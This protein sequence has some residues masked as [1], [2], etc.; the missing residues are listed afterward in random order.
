M[1][2]NLSTSSLARAITAVPRVRPGPIGLDLGQQR[3]H[4]VQMNAGPEGPVIRARRSVAY[5][6]G[7]DAVLASPKALKALYREATRRMGFSGHRVVTC[8]PAELVQLW[9]ESYRMTV[10]R[11]EGAA[12]LALALERVGGTAEDWVV[13]YIPLR[14]ASADAVDRE[15]IIACCRREHVMQRL[16][17][18]SRA[19]LDVEAVEVGP[20]AVRRL[21]AAVSACTAQENLLTVNVGRASTF[22]TIFAGRRLMVE[23]EAAVGEADL[24]DRVARNLEIDLAQAQRLVYQHGFVAPGT[25][26]AEFSHTLATILKPRLLD[27]ADE[28]EKVVIYTASKLRGAAVDRIFLLGSLARWPGAADMLNRLVAL[29]VE[30][31]NPVATFMPRGDAPVDPASTTGIFAALAAGSALRGIVLDE[32]DDPSTAVGAALAAGSAL[33][34][35]VPG[36]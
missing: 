11:S 21:V 1:L 31:M 23:R 29:P 3:L 25:A 2:E 4:L 5:P 26:G 13:D 28:I 30:V 36:V 33:R 32:D 22:L 27:L 35:I 10:D 16:D 6:G 14:R 24:L 8:M 9:P 19:G 34:G 12:L 17:L 15:A 7:R 18:L 20:V